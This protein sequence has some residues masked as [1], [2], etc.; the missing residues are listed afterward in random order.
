L[1]NST[2]S[3]K[4]DNLAGA[5]NAKFP[6]VSTIEDSPRWSSLITPQDYRIG[7]M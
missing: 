7:A 6:V 4:A 5:E 2:L 3:R 1:E